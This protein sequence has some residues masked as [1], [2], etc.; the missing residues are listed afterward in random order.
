MAAPVPSSI[1]D[2]GK[3]WSYVPPRKSMSVSAVLSKV[4]GNSRQVTER[5]G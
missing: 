3:L 5:A 2:N 4:W 1:I